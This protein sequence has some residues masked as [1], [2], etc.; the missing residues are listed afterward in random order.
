MPYWRE[1]KI[2]SNTKHERERKRDKPLFSLNLKVVKKRLPGRKCQEGKCQ[3]G[4][5]QGKKKC[6]GEGRYQEEGKCQGSTQEVSSKFQKY[7]ES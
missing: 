1:E 4:N 3:E 5:C 6:Q 7:F 2:D